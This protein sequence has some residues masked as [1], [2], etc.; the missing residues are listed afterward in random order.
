MAVTRLHRPSRRQAGWAWLARGLALV[1][2]GLYTFIASIVVYADSGW[3]DDERVHAAGAIVMGLVLVTS[4][5][6]LLIDPADRPALTQGGLALASI[7]LVG[8]VVGNPNNHGG[9]AG[10]YDLAYLVAAVP[11]LALAAVALRL[12]PTIR[13]Q[14]PG[15][16][17]LLL[18]G[19]AALIAL[20]PYA[21]DQAL[22]QRN[23]WPP[24]ADPHHNAHWATMAHVGLLVPS[25][26]GLAAIAAA[27][28]RRHAWLAAASAGMLGLIWLL[29]P[30]DV[31]SL[32]IG[33]GIAALLWSVAIAPMTSSSQNRWSGER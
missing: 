28:W 8:V 1:T 26:A 23:S 10:V 7:L 22:A 19:V 31:S 2:L 11:F 24:A 25:L 13:L 9:Q 32:G 6:W 18:L 4:L 21:L 12:P 5:I 16:R 33:G 15:R 17:T 29:Y 14:S 27:R 30:D 3:T 20:I